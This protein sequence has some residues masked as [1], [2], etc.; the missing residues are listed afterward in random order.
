MAAVLVWWGREG[1]GEGARGGPVA[2]GVAV[3]TVVGGREKS[4]KG[5]KRRGGDSEE[6]GGDGRGTEVHEHPGTDQD[7]HLQS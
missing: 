6:S 7:L 5:R 3:A 4:G 1:G 2:V